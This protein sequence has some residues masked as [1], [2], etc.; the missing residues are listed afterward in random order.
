ML[1]YVGVAILMRMSFKDLT[2]L[3]INNNWDIESFRALR[4]TTPFS[5]EVAA[6]SVHYQKN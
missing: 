4:P 3:N 5:D 2:L 1:N 6:Y